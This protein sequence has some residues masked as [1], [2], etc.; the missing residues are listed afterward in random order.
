MKIDPETPKSMIDCY[1]AGEIGPF[2]RTKLSPFDRW[3]VEP[4][5]AE[6]KGGCT[7]MQPPFYQSWGLSLALGCGIAADDIPGTGVHAIGAN[8][9]WLIGGDDG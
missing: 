3:P 1:Q 6:Q 9:D 4:M 2:Y 7:Y 8:G 5:S